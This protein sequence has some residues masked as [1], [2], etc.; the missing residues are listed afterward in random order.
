MTTFNQEN[1]QVSGNQYN[2][3]GDLI[4]NTIQ[5]I[6]DIPIE[7]QKLSLELSKATQ[8]GLIPANVSRDA[9]AKIKEAIIEIEKEK[10]NSRTVLDRLNEAKALIDGIVSAAGLVTI[11]AQSVE[12]LEKFL[13][14]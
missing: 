12:M 10:P 9:E 1:Q 6:S 8:N 4:I 14:R 3:G 13:L 5:T 11:M 7:L 2:T